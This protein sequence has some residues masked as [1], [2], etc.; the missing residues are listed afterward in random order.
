MAENIPL[1]QSAAN[2]LENKILILFHWCSQILER[3]K[4]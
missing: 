2:Y 4:F 3:A 1:I